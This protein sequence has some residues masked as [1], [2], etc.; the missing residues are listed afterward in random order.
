M[1]D[2]EIMKQQSKTEKIQQKNCIRVNC[3]A[4]PITT[5]IN[6]DNVVKWNFTFRKKQQKK[7]EAE[8]LYELEEEIKSRL[9]RAM[10]CR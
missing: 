5:E 4:V 3:R 6:T 10:T 9:S 1:S 8:Y 7:S 2:F